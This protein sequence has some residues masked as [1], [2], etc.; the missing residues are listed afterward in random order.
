[1]KLSIVTLNYKTPQLTIACVDSVYRQF[2]KEFESDKLEHLI[3]DNFSNDDSVV[4]IEKTLK[5]RAYKNV[6]LIKNSENAGFGRGCN[7]G[8]THAEGEF[9]LFLNSDTQVENREF[10][11]MMDFLATHPECAILGGKMVNADGSPQL[12]AAKFY[13][14]IY[15]LLMLL[16]FERLGFMKHSPKNIQQ[17]DW[18]SGGCMMVNKKIFE[19]IGGFDKHIFMYMEDME[20]CF[21]AKQKGYTTY[22]YPSTKVIHAAQG[23]SNRTFAIVNIYHGILYFY[24]KYMPHWQ[25]FLIQWLLRIKAYFLIVIGKLTGNTYLSSTYEKAL[26][27]I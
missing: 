3:V 23:S 5:E 24:W 16:G 6:K 22:F 1:M 11:S 13:T 25:F 2:T 8:V 19:K 7:F 27:A 26:A 21:R 15:I 10:I 20:L 17:V 14:F 4:K 9:V 12:S 18:V